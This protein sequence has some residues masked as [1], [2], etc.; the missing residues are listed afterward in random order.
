MFMK[1]W[2][3]RT[4]E[5]EHLE[6]LFK[7]LEI[8]ILLWSVVSIVISW[9]YF[10]DNY[11]ICETLIKIFIIELTQNKQMISRPKKETKTAPWKR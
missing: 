1:S 10:P 9:T 5:K 8:T 2:Q 11:K 4:V 3:N 7:F 6:L